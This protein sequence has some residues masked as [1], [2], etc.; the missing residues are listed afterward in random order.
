[1]TFTAKAIPIPRT[2]PVS[3]SPAEPP[4]IAAT[5]LAPL[6][7]AAPKLTA[8]DGYVI[9]S[10]H[11]AT[12]RWRLLA[13][14]AGTVAPLEVPERA[15]PF[16]AEAGPSPSGA[17][18]IV[19]SKCSQDPS[20]EEVEGIELAGGG[21]WGGAVGCHIY[22]LALPGG[23]PKLIRGLY[24]A[25]ASDTTPA[26]W[27]NEIAF[28]RMR[29]G[30]RAPTLYIWNRAK[31]RLNRVG[32]GPTTCQSFS[33]R[34]PCNRKPQVLAWVE[35]M[36]LDAGSLAYQWALPEAI[37]AFGS[38]TAQIR[39]DPLRGARQDKPT[40][41]IFDSIPGGACNGEQAAS[42]DAAGSRV[43]YIW[44]R[45]VCVGEPL[46][47]FIADFETATLASGEVRAGPLAVAVAQDHSTTY[48][49]SLAKAPGTGLDDYYESCAPA[50]SA[51]TLMRSEDLDGE[52]KPG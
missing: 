37:P 23:S 45:S 27:R 40:K 33:I 41:V 44:H 1:V 6:E 36:S 48:W 7:N 9:F 31:G 22:E 34:Q 4:G 2:A 46:E 52:L 32:A 10:R 38:A 3:A 47:S 24:T 30:A 21:E 42:P 12:G 19:F 25:K 8:Y 28:A 17:P 35:E 5:A 11:E 15:V 13:W 43:L 20:L 26:I 16:D 18:A 14:H 49:I 29:H 39:V 51:C 50:L